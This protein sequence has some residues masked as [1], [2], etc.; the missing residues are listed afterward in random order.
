MWA[1]RRGNLSVRLLSMLLVVPLAH[2]APAPPQGS[3][4]TRGAYYTSADFS[5]VAKR[6]AH[7]HI[8]TANPALVLQAQEDNFS[9]L[10]INVDTPRYPPIDEQESI[11][12]GLMKAFPDRLT[13]AATFSAARFNTPG[14]RDEALR[15]LEGSLARG[16]VA[17]K[18]WKNIGMEL[19]DARGAFV[20][21]DDASF[22][23]LIEF[24][25][26]QGAVI[27]G[28]VGEPRN[29]WLPLAQ[30]TVRSDRAYYEEHPE[31]HMYLHPEYPSYEQH[32]Q[33]RDRMLAKHPQTSF[34]GAHLGSM[35]WSV[36]E[37]AT[38]LDRF[39]QMSV[40]LAARMPHLQ[41]Q[42]AAARDK[43]RSFF[44]KYQDRIIY[45][46]DQTAGPR[47]DPAAVRTRAHAT[48]KEDWTFL[49]SDDALRSASVAGSFRGLQLPREVVD[50]VYRLNSERLRGR[51]RGRAV[52]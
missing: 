21:I 50:K 39:P 45:G 28:H 11:A 32:L 9:L 30:M 37:L 33:A 13:Y 17:V 24:I 12:V 15:H 3:D 43:V 51:P 18:F 1:R 34:I 8:N 42:A 29:C 38:R 26:G 4:G 27:I 2:C 19:K 49:T 46:T 14:W 20:A 25:T 44:I 35:E 48:W 47:R 6:D 10:T 36:D 40:D 41:Y 5:S 22:D 23:P 31:Y 52:S 7:V 16:A